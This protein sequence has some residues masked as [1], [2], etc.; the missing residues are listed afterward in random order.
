MDIGVHSSA[1]PARAQ[2]AACARRRPG[3]RISLAVN[4][5]IFILI[6]TALLGGGAPQL[7]A[8][9]IT[10]QVQEE[11]RKRN[12]YFGDIDG[13]VSPSVC[14]ALTS[15]QQR[16]GFVANGVL[17]E[18]TL[19]SFG[20]RPPSAS[21]ATWPDLPVLKSDV[22]VAAPAPAPIFP[23]PASA[24]A[25]KPE[26]SADRARLFVEKYLLAGQSNDPAAEA[27][28]YADRVDYF[29]SG[30]V[31]RAFV[32]RDIRR[33][34]QRW[35]ERYFA[36]EGKVRLLPTGEPDRV[37]VKLTYRFNVKGR[38]YSVE[39][40]V[41]TTYTLMGDQPENWR[42]VRVREHRIAG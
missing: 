37:K 17:T 14:G 24:L 35:P 30:K 22:A 28:M 16:K 32:E 6:A 18:E 29:D 20:L 4:T 42:I 8:D 10:R 12:L 13:R 36:I 19:R 40:K 39:G 23:P 38:K 7:R 11:L 5:R 2:T 27:A 3:T 15:Y 31:S 41:G 25:I 1:L 21:A 33:Y 9:D 26:A 34:N